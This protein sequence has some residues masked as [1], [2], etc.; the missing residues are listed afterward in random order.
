LSPDPETM[1][2]GPITYEITEPLNRVRYA[3]APNDVVPISFD[4]EMTGVAPPQ[5]EE[6]EVHTSRS[7][8]RVDA[9]VVRFHQ[10]G[11][12]NGWVEVEG[13]RTSIEDAQWVAAR[14]RSWGVR[15][16]VGAPPEDLE[17]A[18]MP[19]GTAG[20]FVW[21]PVTMTRR[22]TGRPYALHVYSQRYGGPGWSTGSQQGTIELANGRRIPFDAIDLDLRFDDANRR[23]LG[24]T[25]SATQADGTVIAYAV[26]P[27]SETGFHLGTGL[28]GGFEGHHHGEY[29]GELNVE[30]EH[31]TDCDDPSVARRIH[32]HRDCIVRLTDP[33]SGDVGYGSMQSGVVG[34]HPTMGLT[35]ANSFD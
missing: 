31:I 34:A 13:V 29:R 16:Q 1:A 9:D 21:M 11:V 5:L 2:V 28:Y 12:A 7:R 22:E 35:E 8:Y 27:V 3:L 23:L 30:G 32:Q 6:Q 20:M 17:P 19:E 14:D 25:I 15:Y 10:A 4:F 33:A 24:G 26:E 18:P